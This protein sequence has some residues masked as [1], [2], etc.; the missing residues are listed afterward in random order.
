MKAEGVEEHEEDVHRRRLEN[1]YFLERAL[2]D[3][4]TSCVRALPAP[5]L[6]CKKFYR[7]KQ[8]SSNHDLSFSDSGPELGTLSLAIVLGVQQD[9][10]YAQRAHR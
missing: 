8:K 5:S 3:A 9:S 10:L 2:N 6:A 4:S 7:L 1:E